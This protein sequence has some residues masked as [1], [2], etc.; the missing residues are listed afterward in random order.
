MNDT[1][2]GGETHEHNHALRPDKRPHAAEDTGIHNHSINRQGSTHIDAGPRSRT[3]RHT[4]HGQADTHNPC[5][6]M[7]TN[8]RAH[9]TTHTDT[10][11]YTRHIHNTETQTHTHSTYTRTHKCTQEHP[12]RTQKRIHMAHKPTHNP[13]LTPTIIPP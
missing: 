11:T 8:T 7:H 3:G 12:L 2:T 13:R 5:K 10:K 1:N 4:Q 6:H 9:T